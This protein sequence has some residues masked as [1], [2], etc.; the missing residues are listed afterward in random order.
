MHVVMMYIIIHDTLDYLF[1]LPLEYAAR[2]NLSE[3]SKQ[4]LMYPFHMREI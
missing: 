2:S 3:Q 1:G 4:G